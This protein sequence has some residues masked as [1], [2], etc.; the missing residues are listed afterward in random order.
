LCHAG[1]TNNVKVKLKFLDAED[2]ENGNSDSLQELDG[3][4]VP[5]GFGE[6]GIEGKIKAIEFARENK[7]PFYGICLGMQLAVIEFARNVC[8]M[9]KANSLE[10]DPNTPDPVISLM[11]EQKAIYDKGATMR[12]GAYQCAL[13]KGSKAYKAYG[14]KEINERHRHR[15][16]FNNQ[17]EETLS[18]KGLKIAGKSTKTG[19]VELVE[20]EDHPW[21]LACQFHPE[22]KSSPSSP[23]PLFVSFVEASVTQSKKRQWQNQRPLPAG[24]DPLEQKTKKA[25]G[26]SGL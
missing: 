19:L 18:K 24:S 25:T 11:E 12:L 3:V 6:R 16:E 23:H 5:G 10:F 4:L 17:Y 22:F 8:G 26:A 13:E 1:T 20:L 7:I 14:E 2:L 21:F 9:S 15:Y